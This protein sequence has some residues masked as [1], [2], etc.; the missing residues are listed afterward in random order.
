M[1]IYKDEL[2]APEKTRDSTD[3][4]AIGHHRKSGLVN[5]GV[6]S[7]CILL[8]ATGWKVFQQSWCHCF[9]LDWLD[10]DHFYNT[11]FSRA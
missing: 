5:F 8:I 11:V 1:A 3:E 9:M 6:I 2:Y 10:I 4:V 7:H